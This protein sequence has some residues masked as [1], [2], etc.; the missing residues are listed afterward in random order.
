MRTRTWMT[1]LGAGSLLLTGVIAAIPTATSAQQTATPPT[2]VAEDAT[3][4]PAIIGTPLF[5]PTIDLIQAQEIALDGQSGASVTGVELEGDDGVL[6]YDVELD[7]GNEVEVDATSGAV[8]RTD[9]G[10]DEGDDDGDDDG[11]E[12]GEDD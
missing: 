1:G 4:G 11:E 10:D 12:G 3:N 5:R 8:I 2:Q 6:V 9:T 7:N